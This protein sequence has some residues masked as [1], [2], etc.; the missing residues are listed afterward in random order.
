MFET[1]KT[2]YLKL[3][4][5]TVLRGLAKHTT[6]K[7]YCLDNVI[8]LGSMSKLGPKKIPIDAVS[9]AMSIDSDPEEEEYILDLNK[10]EDR[11]TFFMNEMQ[12]IING[13]FAANFS[14]DEEQLFMASSLL[15]Q[16]I[17]TS[18]GVRKALMLDGTD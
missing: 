12:E 16:S 4:N 8:D 9:V 11:R 6:S 18:D 15:L 5:D 1:G 14:M 10:P 7:D 13:F 2:I 3:E 17:V